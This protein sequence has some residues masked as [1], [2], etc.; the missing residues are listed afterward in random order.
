MA[1]GLCV[2]AESRRMLQG[3][4]CTR[5]VE[6]GP[7]VTVRRRC[8]PVEAAW[9]N[10]NSSRVSLSVVSSFNCNFVPRAVRQYLIYF[11]YL[12][13]RSWIAPFLAISLSFP[14]FPVHPSDS[15]SRRHVC[16]QRCRKFVIDVIA[17]PAG[18]LFFLD[19]V[20]GCLYICRNLPPI[21]I[22]VLSQ[23]SGEQISICERHPASAHSHLPDLSG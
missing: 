15:V 10:Y 5:A 23:P 2:S 22:S 7:R 19:H 21:T 20:L 8:F 6:S 13:V 14:S 9:S 1:S 3:P 18:I 11:P 12:I 17:I 16:E 4:N